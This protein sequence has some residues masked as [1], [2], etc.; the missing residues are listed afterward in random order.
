MQSVSWTNYLVPSIRSNLAQGHINADK[1]TD[2]LREAIGREAYHG[3]WDL[4]PRETFEKYK[5]IVRPAMGFFWFDFDHKESRGD[6]A[7]KDAKSFIEWLDVD[8]VAVFFS[9]SKGFH[10]GV[11]QG[12]FGLEPSKDL[13][14][15][16]KSFIHKIIPKF[17]TLD[18]SVH[19]AARKFRAP[20]SKHPDT[21][22]HKIRLQIEQLDL[23]I[24]EIIEIAKT[25][26][27]PVNF[28]DINPKAPRQKLSIVEDILEM[29]SPLHH[30]L[31][32]DEDDS[33]ETHLTKGRCRHG[34]H[35]K[36]SALGVALVHKDYEFNRLVVRLM[37]ADQEYNQKADFCYFMCPERH[38]KHKAAIENA[39]DFVDE[40]FRNHGP[41][42]KNADN[43]NQEKPKDR[44]QL[45]SLKDVLEK[46]DEETPYVVEGLLPAG[47]TSIVAAKPKVGKTT[48]LRQLSLS[49]SIGHLFLNRRTSQGPV[50]YF[51]VEEKIDEIKG[52]FKAMGATGN[53]PIYIFA[54]RAPRDTIEQLGPI[55]AEIKPS[56]IILD[57]LFK[58]VRMK[59]ANDY[60]SISE[61]LEPIQDLARKSGAHI[62]CVHHAG[63]ADRE[64]ADGIL[65]STAIL[66]AFDTAI[67]M[68]RSNK[69]RTIKTIQRYGKDLDESVLFFDE[70]TRLSSLGQESWKEK[71]DER[72]KTILDF[73]RSVGIATSFADI[74]A[75]TGIDVKLLR[76]TLQRM[77]DLKL[78]SVRGLGTR[79][80]PKLYSIGLF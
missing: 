35:N 12:Y 45:T 52:H 15:I 67:I 39:R 51:S 44:I 69:R 70:E 80:D 66:G 57:T 49:V 56:L 43:V 4:E 71:A 3:L 11:P 21:G 18:P 27:E 78:I 75:G 20:G 65:G 42:S 53:E 79:N 48:L 77:V 60:A 40:L 13:P 28:S 74:K 34:S 55:I 37:E 38:W 6:L 14:K 9:G 26:P 24:D 61:A 50:I 33:T 47:G 59:D 2:V 64:G 7:R 25:K 17:K 46:P 73:V 68:S 32:S 31:S 23:S 30:D 19:E 1:L 8:D 72:S 54:S 5:G 58:I 16:M 22:F 36:L 76:E 63:K 62:M 41:G 29:P 10:V